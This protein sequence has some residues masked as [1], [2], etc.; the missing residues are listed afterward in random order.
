MIS[1]VTPVYNGEKFIAACLQTVI[2]QHCAAVEHLIIDGNSSDRT[3]DIV[4]DYAQR[5]AHIRWISEPDRGQSDAMNKG[6]R[7]AIGNVITFLNVD[8]YYEPNVLNQVIEQFKTLPEPGFLVGNCQIWNDDEQLIDLNQPAKLRLVDLVLGLNIN[9]Y[10]CNPSAYF[11]H[12]SL[13]N[14]IGEYAIEDHYAMDLDFILRAV[15][16]AH[17]RYVDQT[18]GNHRRIQGTKTVIDMAAGNSEKRVQ[19]LLRSYRQF[20]TWSDWLQFI[21][22]RGWRSFKLLTALPLRGLRKSYQAWK[23]YLK[24]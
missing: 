19:R 22:W 20:F 16:V 14:Q 1:I 11:Y 7:L 12:R 15:Q 3:I 4:K 21:V 17:L 9:P 18:W 23:K 6:I 8:D 24:S 13:H 10:P 5:Y 2:D